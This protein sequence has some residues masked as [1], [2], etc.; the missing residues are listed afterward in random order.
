MRIYGRVKVLR[1]G[2]HG[3]AYL[4]VEYKEYRADGS[5]KMIGTEDFS[6]KR[7]S[8]VPMRFIY[9]WNG[10]KLNKGGK[11]W[12]DYEGSMRTDDPK[13]LKK[14]LEKVYADKAV[15]DVRTR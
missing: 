7:W 9:T 8:G 1:E 15:V 12:F 11:R 4:E 13:A 2:E 3:S 14:Y 5:L 6:A 10:E